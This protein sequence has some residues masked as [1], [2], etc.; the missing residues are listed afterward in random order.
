MIRAVIFDLDGTL[1]DSNELHV[2]AWHDTFRHF[3]KDIPLERLREQIGKGGD[4][5]LP[6]F[7]NEREL[8]EFGEEADKYRG[9]VFKKNYL[10]HVK[11]FPK[12]CELFERLRAD[13]KKIALASSGKN[14]EVQH[15]EKLLGIK[16]LVDCMTTSDEV[17]QS[18]PK[19]DVFLAALNL[20]EL[21]ASEAIAVGD[22]PY[23]V[24]AAKKIELPIIGVRCGGF[25]EDVLREEGAIA[26][27]RDP[28]DLLDHYYQSPIAG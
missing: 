1:V 25:S 23:D 19:P 24:E 5:Y 3:H 28:A 12:V 15:Y 2:L 11:P 16:S 20:L 21:L 26:I 18:K 10:P 6:E 9:E 8:R 17:A 22:T 13:G 27:Y 14:A 4:Q 7:L